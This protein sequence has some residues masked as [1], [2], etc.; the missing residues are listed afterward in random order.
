MK[1]QKPWHA[2]FLIAAVLPAGILA[3]CSG[4]VGG[5]GSSGQMTPAATGAGNTPGSASGGGSVVTTGG[6]SG[7]TGAV[8]TMVP[9]STG[10]NTP[11]P[12]ESAGTLL[13][14]RVT[15]SEYDHMLAD[16]LGD[17]TA[18]AED[19]THPWSNDGLD[20]NGFTNPVDT[21]DQT[22]LNINMATDT[23]VDAALAAGKI[24]IPCTN[25]TAAMETSCVTS[26]ITTFGLRA[27]RRP[28]EA[29]EQTDL[30]A[31]FTTVRGLG[32]TFTQ[33][34]AAVV[35]GMLQ[36]GSFLYHWEI[37]PTKPVAGSDGLVP[38]TQWQIA[39]RLAS[40][41]WNTMPDD[42]LLQAAQAGQLATPAQVLAQAQRMIADPKAAQALADFHGQWLLTVGTRIA[43]LDGIPPAGPLTQAGVDSLST[44]FSSFLASVYSTGDGSLSSFLTAPYAFI[45]KDLAPLYGVTAPATGFA[46]V[47]L[48]PTKRGGLF[49][50]VAFLA[51]FATA[52][53][54]NPVLR[55]LSIYTKLLCGQPVA[56]PAVVPKIIPIA[57]GTTRQIYEKHGE[58][59]CAQGCHNAFDPPGFAFENYDGVGLY[60]ITDNGQPVDS[61]GTFTT[62]AGATLTFTNAL[63]LMKQLVTSP[64]AQQCVERQWTR[65]MFGRLETSDEAGSLAVAFQKGA[66]TTGFSL[67]DMVTALVSSKAYLYRRPSAGEML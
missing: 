47:A 39:S 5:P 8:P 51:S 29:A 12:P 66:A 46:K 52:Q 57:T 27:F 50:Q 33:S 7:G 64:E 10:T 38:L 18:P 60:R 24:T 58:N 21:P 42:M 53:D 14:R 41:L 48:D 45:N 59:A 15:L 56:P 32:L 31:L 22:V 63:D 25:P 13:N 62:P 36:S 44:E 49:T 2:Y 30:L 61:S 9:I 19:S 34:V 54:D 43:N 6:G 26:F 3:G 16:L 65:Y 55:G 17:K 20:D 35:K 28:V 67:R 1:A 11:P 4:K 37:G 40:N 23:V